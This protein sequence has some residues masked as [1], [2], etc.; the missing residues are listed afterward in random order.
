MHWRKPN[1]FPSTTF[2]NRFL[3]STRCLNC[4]HGWIE[5]R[6]RS[7]H[8]SAPN[9]YTKRLFSRSFRFFSKNCKQPREREMKER[10]LSQRIT[11]QAAARKKTLKTETKNLKD[12]MPIFPIHNLVFFFSVAR[13]SGARCSW[14]CFHPVFVLHLVNQLLSS[15]SNARWK[16]NPFCSCLFVLRSRCTWFV[17]SE[18]ED[19]AFFMYWKYVSGWCLFNRHIGRVC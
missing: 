5:F 19:Y 16:R 3:L 1:I 11:M 15:T 12:G 4:I 10:C 6:I 14:Y 13:F 17:F 2:E 8:L 18:P 9:A 7:A